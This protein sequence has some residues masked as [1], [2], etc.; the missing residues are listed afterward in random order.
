MNVL[1]H[2]ESIGF[3][4]FHS[5]YLDTLQSLCLF[6]ETADPSSRNELLEKECWKCCMS[7]EPALIRL[8]GHWLHRCLVGFL[9]ETIR[10]S[11]PLYESHKNVW[12]YLAI[13]LDRTILHDTIN[14]DVG[15]QA[16]NIRPGGFLLTTDP[17]DDSEWMHMVS[18]GNLH[19][20][21]K[22]MSPWP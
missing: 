20:W 17:F 15:D 1:V 22:R 4:P 8:G 21:R 10:I 13:L 3:N 6:Y 9:P 12:G 7:R 19:L 5:M 2:A 18:A 14:A 16:S 11:T